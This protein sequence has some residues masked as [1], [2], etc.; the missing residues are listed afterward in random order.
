MNKKDEK[1][2][3]EC[4]LKQVY[5]HR[6]EIID[7]INS[8][9]G[10]MYNDFLDYRR[11]RELQRYN[12]EK[13][14]IDKK[15]NDIKTRIT[16]INNYLVEQEKIDFICKKENINDF[17][18]DL[19]NLKNV[20]DNIILS[21]VGDKSIRYDRENKYLFIV[22]DHLLLNIDR[23]DLYACTTDEFNKRYDAINFNKL[24]KKFN[25][26]RI[27]IRNEERFRR[28]DYVCK[29]GHVYVR[30]SAI[31]ILN[32]VKNNSDYTNILNYYIDNESK[33]FQKR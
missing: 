15:T 27:Q 2:Q 9:E 21:N 3:L 20:N 18:I 1:F 30:I 19:D 7:V 12:E 23:D 14:E 32:N 33:L 28:H 26:Y 22:D 10:K 25:I 11:E 31:I 4:E 6:D 29:N 16:S 5:K 24:R 13:K 17:D 8:L